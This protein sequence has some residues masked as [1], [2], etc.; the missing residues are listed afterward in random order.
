MSIFPPEDDYPGRTEGICG[1]FNGDKTDDLGYQGSGQVDPKPDTHY[2]N[3]AFVKSWE[4][5]FYAYRPLVFPYMYIY[6]VCC[7]YAEQTV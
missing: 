5:V 2:Q 6:N 3:D 7:Y 4:L 1:N